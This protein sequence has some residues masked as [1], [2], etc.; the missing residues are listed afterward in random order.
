M[1]PTTKPP[2]RGTATAL[3]T[4]VIAL[5][6]AGLPAAVDP[7]TP[8]PGTPPPPPPAAGTTRPAPD[9]L[10]R[11]IAFGSCFDPRREGGEIFFRVAE[12]EPDLF[13]FIGDTV[14]ADTEDP[15]RYAAAFAE[16][17][18]IP[19]YVHLRSRV[20]VAAV[21]DDHD[22]GRNDAGRELA[23]RAANQ[24]LFLDA[25]GEPADSPRRS[26]PGIHHAFTTGPEGARV[27]V[28]LLDT[29]FFRSP[30]RTE[31]G[32]TRA[33]WVDGHPGRYLPVDDPD[34]TM[35]GPEQWA[36]LADRLREPADVRIIASSIQ[37]LPDGHRF[38]KWGNMPRERSRLL[39]LIAET[40]AGGAVLISGDR[41]R[42]EL[43]RLDAS[44]AGYPLLELTS[45]AM[46]RG[47]G[48]SMHEI[49]ELRVGS[50][51][52]EHNFGLIELEWGEDPAVVLMLCRDDGR[53][54]LRHRIRLADLQPAA[55]DRDP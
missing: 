50:V 21:W 53:T 22:Y 34:A 1:L 46:N 9:T 10:I 51:L 8:V 45:S 31:E 42:A 39:H 4:A 20:P 6:A 23:A 2:R 11:R 52:S 54:W 55:T 14:Y 28:I 33:D 13:L 40:G 49:N 29:R 19:G 36:W 32:R 43:S 37:V 18:E 44:P 3:A 7:S 38:E 41:H 27:Q 17:R 30:L 26:R 5:A 25:F 12:R 15:E 35:L 47:G 24:Q 48:G 16:L